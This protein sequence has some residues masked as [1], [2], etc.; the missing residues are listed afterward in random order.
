MVEKLGE[1]KD[2]LTWKGV[3]NLLLTFVSP[4]AILVAAPYI[5]D[6]Q[7]IKFYNTILPL[8][9]IIL[10]CIVLEFSI[11][12]LCSL[13]IKTIDLCNKDTARKRRKTFKKHSP[14]LFLLNILIIIFLIVSVIIVIPLLLAKIRLPLFIFVPSISLFITASLYLSLM[15]EE[16]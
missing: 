3:I 4:I 15:K 6:I 9:E 12:I 16:E 14:Y 10:L 8:T 11:C 1:L 5:Y 2:Y 13:K 7:N